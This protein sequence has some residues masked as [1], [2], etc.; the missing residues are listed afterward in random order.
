MH[1]SRR[2]TALEEV[3]AATKSKR[4]TRSRIDRMV[5][6][7]FLGITAEDLQMEIP[8]ARVLAFTTKGRSILKEVKKSGVYLNAGE[9]Y[10]HPYWALEKRCG[11]LYGLFCTDGIEPPCPEENRRIYYQI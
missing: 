5:M 1:A 11:D 7:A 3:I 8:Y 9:A 6:C 10:D 2:E 4:Y